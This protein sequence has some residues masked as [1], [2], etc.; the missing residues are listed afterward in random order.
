MVV[1]LST[2]AGGGSGAALRVLD[3]PRPDPFTGTDGRQLDLRL[4]GRIEA[5]ERDFREVI[6]SG[7]KGV[8][9]LEQRVT[10][11]ERRSLA[12]DAAFQK[13]GD[14]LD[15]I[16]ERISRMEERMGVVHPRRIEP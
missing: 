15:D 5:L 14:K 7:I 2:L 6:S 1:V 11:C 4:S 10:E 3:P 8:Q 9:L 13:I 12:M 16:R